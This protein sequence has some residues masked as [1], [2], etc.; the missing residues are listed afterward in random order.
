MNHTL[1]ALAGAALLASAAA[2]ATIVDFDSTGFLL[3]TSGEV[4]TEQ[5]FDFTLRQG[6]ADAGLFGGFAFDTVVNNGSPNLL[7]LNDAT[8]ELGSHDGT[9]FTLNSFQLGGGEIDQPAS[10]ATYLGVIGYGTNGGVMSTLV[11]LPA[12]A[13]M[14]TASIGWSGLTKA[15]LTPFRLGGSGYDDR[16]YTLDNVNLTPVPEPSGLALMGIGLL[17]VGWTLRRRAG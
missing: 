11:L 5:G 15:V 16:N 8:I 7:A 17:A 9:A 14:V 4:A 10:W 2:Q 6:N 12:D 3:S 13:A 1:K